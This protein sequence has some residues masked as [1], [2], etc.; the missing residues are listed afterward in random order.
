MKP[1]HAIC[2]SKS[3]TKVITSRHEDS[4]YGYVEARTRVLAVLVMNTDKVTKQTS[5]PIVRNAS[6]RKSN[7]KSSSKR[8]AKNNKAM[9][10]VLD[11]LNDVIDED[12]S[13]TENEKAFYEG[14]HPD[15]SGTYSVQEIMGHQIIKA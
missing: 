6:I 10:R 3:I 7:Q 12:G 8:S 9:Q 11:M 13:E 1:L 2:T 5:R 14:L 15:G 4:D